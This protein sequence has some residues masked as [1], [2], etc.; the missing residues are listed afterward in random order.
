MEIVNEMCTNINGPI[1]LIKSL[2]T[3]VIIHVCAT[4]KYVFLYFNIFPPIKYMN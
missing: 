2:L 4:S 3:L 1:L